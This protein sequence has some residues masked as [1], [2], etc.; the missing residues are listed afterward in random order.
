VGRLTD[1]EVWRNEEEE[2]NEERRRM[3]RG[4]EGGEG[5][6]GGGG[7]TERRKND[8]TS[9]AGSLVLHAPYPL[10]LTLQDVSVDSLVHEDEDEDKTIER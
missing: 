10:G 1:E 6:E 3:K 8:L 4:G 9:C 2:E 5:G 7:G